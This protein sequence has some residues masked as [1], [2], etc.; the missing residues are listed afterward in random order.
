MNNNT[1][2]I[3]RYLQ[4][5]MSDEEKSAFERQLAYD[6]ELQEELAIQ[7]Q[8]VAAV[9]SVGLKNAFGKAIR[10]KF[11]SRILI[12]WGI[13]ALVVTGL[14]FYAFKTNMFSRS[15][16]ETEIISGISPTETF[17]IDNSA[18]TIIETDEGVVFGIP[19]NAFNTKS[20]KIR[21]EIKTAISPEKIML[22]G[23]ST[24]SNG[25]LLQTGGMFSIHGYDKNKPLSMVKKIDVSVPAKNV[26]PAMQLFNGV[27]DS[28]GRINWVDPKPIEKSLRT[29][30]ITTLDFYPPYYVPVL[31]ALGKDYMD[32]EYTD[33]LYYSFSG[34]PY[35][36]SGPL[37]LGPITK[38]SAGKIVLS[39]PKEEIERDYSNRDTLKRTLT[40]SIRKNHLDYIERS[41]EIDPSRIRVIW[42]K[43]FNN[44]IIA[45]KEFEERLR[46]MHTICSPLFLVYLENLN[47]PMHEIDQ[48]IADNAGEYSDIQHKFLEFAARKD[49]GVMV[50]EGMQE[51]LSIY[52]EKKFKAYTDASAKTWA[53]H[54][55][56]L[57]RLAAIADDKRREQE[58][59]DFLRK[60][61]ILQEEFCINLTDAYR[62]IGV[63]R[64]CKDTIPVPPP[65]NYYNIQIDTV[66][67]KN[68]DMYVNEATTARE[69]MTYTDPDTGKTAT[70]TY[71][72]VSISI[73]DQQ[74]FDRIFVY[75]LPDG[76]TS[77]QRIEQYGNVFNEKL[78]SLFRYDA[79]VVGFKGDQTYFYR[80]G[81]VQPGQHSF[82][83][84]AITEKEL[85]QVLKSGV[86]DNSVEM[87]NEYEFQL[88]EQQ[89]VRRE[90]ELRKKRDFITQ[91]MTVIWPCGEGRF[92]IAEGD[93]LG[94]PSA[95]STSASA[96]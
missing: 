78:N 10:T 44:T 14:V 84:S 46:Y 55:E 83:L 89:E 68:L 61:K 95:D 41:Y 81:N 80:Q 12:R 76:L 24:T 63:K 42:D 54:E 52:F 67:W 35:G 62:Q 17:V 96:Q 2:K 1:E 47:K 20:K 23:L 70:M 58:T 30:D 65:T 25:Q 36:D 45:T 38:D 15:M 72:E 40:D 73:E 92:A 49:G 27:Q 16:H 8:L 56:E 6:K 11:I 71:K 87:Y 86:K 74:Q 50:K 93:E 59:K 51:T 19:A 31:K 57:A 28:S 82:R 3:G 32:K 69:S 4:N 48:F 21:L 94:V 43:K 9:K 18:D 5:E 90:I 13:V 79:V 7:K 37:F 39:K 33:S 34:Y 29:Y 53:K 77:F 88:F 85:K 91:I 66:G 26:N 75:L 60:D 64:T 22:Q